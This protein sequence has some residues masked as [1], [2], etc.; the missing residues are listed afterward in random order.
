MHLVRRKVVR[1]IF[2]SNANPK[3]PDYYELFNLEANFTDAQLKSSYLELVKKY[4]PDLSL[5]DDS[6]DIFKMVQDGY[7]IL[8]NP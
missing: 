1:A 7:A 2:C 3:V 5:E 4:H 8:S 6:K